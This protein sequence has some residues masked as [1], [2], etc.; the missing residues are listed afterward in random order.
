MKKFL[1]CSLV[2]VLMCC[3]YI[4]AQREDSNFEIEIRET[5]K[6]QCIH[7]V[8][9]LTDHFAKI[10]MKNEADSIKD[11]HIEACMDL[12]VGR[13]N[14]TKD[15]EGNV[16]IPAPR[17]EVSSRSTGQ[18]NSY[19]IRNY[20]IRIKNRSYTKIVFKTSDCFVVGEDVK[21]IGENRYSAAVSFYQV[22]IGYNGD[23]VVTRNETKKTVEVIIERNNYGSGIFVFEI[24]LG[25]IKV[26][27]IT[28][29]N[30]R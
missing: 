12:F 17:I 6:Q 16:I 14:D 1:L 10:A 18:V 11:Y 25:N 26:D 8:R 29:T 15:D 4:T 5:I 22:F 2:D 3:N 20:L 19:F 21:K 23:M 7:K 27:Q 28:E 30:Q 13:G 24:R 9:A